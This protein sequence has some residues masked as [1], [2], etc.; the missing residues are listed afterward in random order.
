M[1]FNN[2]IERYSQYFFTNKRLFINEM[3]GSLNKYKSEMISKYNNIIIFFFIRNSR[4]FCQ[5]KYVK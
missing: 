1:V 3:F 4:N 2:F 5:I